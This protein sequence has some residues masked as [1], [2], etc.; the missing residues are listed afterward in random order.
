[1]RII[2]TSIG[3][4]EFKKDK[5]RSNSLGN[6]NSLSNR[7]ENN[8]QVFINEDKMIQNKLVN[9]INFPKIKSLNKSLFLN[10]IQENKNNSFENRPLYKSPKSEE[11]NANPIIFK[12]IIRSPKT[13]NNNKILDNNIYSPKY[14]IIYIK[15]K[16]LLIPNDKDF[17]YSQE[18]MENRLKNFRIK[19]NNNIEKNDFSSDDNKINNNNLDNSYNSLIKSSLSDVSLPFINKVITIKDIINN[20]NKEKMKKKFLEKKINVS[21]SNLIKYLKLDKTLKPSFIEKVNN[22]N[23][24]KISQINKICSKYFLHEEKNNILQNKIKNKMEIRKIK[25]MESY[26]KNLRNM[27]SELN[28]YKNICKSLIDKRDNLEEARKFNFIHELYKKKFQ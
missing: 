2:L 19:S 10:D 28:N 17:K 27:S 26:R 3:K 9:K 21:Q 6:I 4:E 18:I 7:K 16:D 12:N 14:K 5:D 24:R 11:T 23:T 8:N 1:M 20:K 13:D 22:A 15:K 25:R